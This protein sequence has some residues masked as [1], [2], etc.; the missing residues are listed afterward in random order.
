MNLI[1]ITFVAGVTGFHLLPLLPDHRWLLAAMAIPI[2]W[3]Y[4]RLRPAAALLAGFCWSFLNASIQLSALLPPELEGRDLTLTG[5]ISSIPS[6]KG[7]ITRFEMDVSTVQSLQGDIAGPE[8][9]RL[10]W[11]KT[12]QTPV[13]G[14]LWQLKVR[15]KRPRGW[16]NPGGFDYARWLFSHGIQATGYVRH[17]DGNQP[18]GDGYR[19][20]WLDRLRMHIGAE[21]NQRFEGARTAALIRALAI[22]DRGGMSTEDW[23]AF[24]RT[25][26][27]HLV[28]I[29]GLHIGMV[30]GLMFFLGQWLWRRS[31][32]LMLRLATVRAGAWLA[33]LSATVYAALAGFSLPTQRALIMLCLGLGAVLI[34]RSL[35]LSRSLCLALFGVVLLDPWAPLSAGFWLSFGAVAVILFSLSGR[36]SRPVGWRQWGRVQWVVALG[37]LPL[38]FILFN[39]A[40][41]IAPLVNLILVPWFSLVLVPLVLLSVSLMALPVGFLLGLTGGLTELTLHGLDW[42][43]Q[44][45]YALVYRPDLP[46][47]VWATAIA[48]VLFILLPR[49]MPGRSLGLLLVAPML[50]NQPARPQEGSLLFT[51]LDVGQG[52][53]CV[54]ET[55]EHVLVFDTGPAFPSGF[56]TAE[57]VLIPYLHSRGIRRIDQ[58]IVSNGDW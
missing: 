53:S 57:A 40:S 38:L 12:Q 35:S 58:L 55:A 18:L 7:L 15:L 48:G 16:Q 24:T 4:A 28:A 56:N 47:W 11:Y 27:N 8:K 44:L 45:P 23:E 52:L 22:G 25:G 29:S 2:C 39:K 9:V 41:V 20:G 36:L 50:L 3:R 32:W 14:Q 43:S 42:A 51:L 54:V 19:A 37:L 49:G 46:V 5:V 10:S 21:I 34:G 31:E 13:P 1:L 6:Q 30:A 33:L 17:W 26:T